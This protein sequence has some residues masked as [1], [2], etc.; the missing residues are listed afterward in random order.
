MWKNRP[1]PKNTSRE[2]TG[3]GKC[4]LIIVHKEYYEVQMGNGKAP[5]QQGLLK[6]I[7]RKLWIVEKDLSRHTNIVYKKGPLVYYTRTYITSSMYVVV[8]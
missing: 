7:S 1:I 2:E 4:S 5:E 3:K 8:L 6:I